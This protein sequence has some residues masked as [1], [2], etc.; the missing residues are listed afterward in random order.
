VAAAVAVA[1][2]AAAVVVEQPVLTE[3]SCDQQQQLKEELKLPAVSVV[4][5]RAVN[6]TSMVLV[7]TD[8][9]AKAVSVATALVVAPV[10]VATTVVVVVVV[11][12][13]VTVTTMTLAVLEAQDSWALQLAAARCRMAFAMAMG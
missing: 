7:A 8:H 6:S 3:R 4:Q 1:L 2:V 11:T 5:T 12:T 13:L 9:S 10:V